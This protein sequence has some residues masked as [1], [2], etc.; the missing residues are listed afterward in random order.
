[1]KLRI[2]NIGCLLLLLALLP[3]LGGCNDEDD[4]VEIFTGKTWKLSFIA[5]EGTYTQYNFWGEKGMND[6]NP[7]FVKSMDLL[8]TK[9]NYTLTF[10]GSDINNTVGGSFKGKGVNVSFE[11]T[12]KADGKTHEL[13]LY[14]EGQLSDES[15]ILAKSFQ[16]G[17]KSASRYEGDSNNL[18]IYYKQGQNTLFMGF[19]P[20]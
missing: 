17:I 7:A 9:G 19:K 15:D 4:V 11:G 1:M 3:V 16:E 6:Q 10:T 14:T 12:W 18:F 13:H 20:Q 8:R 5:A 2:K